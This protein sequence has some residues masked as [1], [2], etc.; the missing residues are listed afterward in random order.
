VI[1]N[2]HGVSKIEEIILDDFESSLL[3][4]S[5]QKLHDQINFAHFNS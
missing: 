5:S 3:K 1:I 4:K 2:Q